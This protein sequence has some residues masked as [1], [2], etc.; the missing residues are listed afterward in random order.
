MK[1]GLR[2]TDWVLGAVVVLVVLAFNRA[3]DLIPSLEQKA[4]DLGVQSTSRLPSDKV[5]VIAIDDT[6]IA[7]I[8]RWPWSREIHA[9]MTDLLAGAKTKVIA[10]TVFFSEPQIDP[11]YVYIT[12]LLDLAT[13]PTPEMAPIVTLLKEAEQTLNTDRRLAESYV[14]AGNVLLTDFFRIDL[15]R[16]QPDRALPG[17]SPNDD[18]PSSH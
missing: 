3:S 17:Y 1:A 10:N 2:R 4:Y 8:G 6:S 5:A 7:N 12:K 13:A 11:G 16:G 15:S 14:K 9:R 18:G